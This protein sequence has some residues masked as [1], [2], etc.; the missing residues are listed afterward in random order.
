[1][2][3]KPMTVAELIAALQVVPQHLQVISEGCDCYGDIVSVE[4]DEESVLL[5]RAHGIDWAF[6]AED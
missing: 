1:M 3:S 2:N 5:R 4:A 6:G